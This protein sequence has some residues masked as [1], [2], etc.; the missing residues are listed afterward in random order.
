MLS[1]SIGFKFTP[2]SISASNIVQT[3]HR[4]IEAFKFG[5][6]YRPFLGDPDFYPEVEKVGDVHIIAKS[7]EIHHRCR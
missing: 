1:L 4:M 5:Y 2:D 3:W 6:A 7:L